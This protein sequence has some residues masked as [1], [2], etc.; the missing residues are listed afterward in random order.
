MIDLAKLYEKRDVFGWISQQL[1]YPE[2]PE[3]QEQYVQ[4][5]DFQRKSTL[6]MTYYKFEDGRERGQLLANLKDTYEQ[7]GLLIADSELPDYL[8]LMCE[9]LYAAD[10]LT[11]KGGEKAVSMI[12]AVIEDGTYHLLSALE[13]ANNPY[14]EVVRT[15]R[16]TVKSCLLPDT[17]MSGGAALTSEG[18]EVAVHD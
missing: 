4:T 18:K 2:E 3:T 12:L 14:A 7:F 8:P 11:H 10:W 9:F 15:L 6:Y 17:D 16:E 13:K 5:F 1:M